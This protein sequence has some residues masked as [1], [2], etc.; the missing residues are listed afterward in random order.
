MKT[1][2]VKK[3]KDEKKYGRRD[4]I[5]L[6]GLGAVAVTAAAITEKVFAEEPEASPT[7]WA[8]VIDLRKCYGCHSCSAACKSGNNVQIGNFRSWVVQVEKGQYPL[9][10]RDFLPRLCNQCEN[11][12]CVRVCPTTATYKRPDGIVEIDKSICIGCR[13][14]VNACPFGMRSFGWRRG[15]DKGKEDYPARRYGVTD[16]CD[17]CFHRL[18]NGMVPSCVNTC[19]AKARIIGNIKDKNSEVYKLID[20]NPT[21][22][23]LPD[24]GT[25]PHVYYIGLDWDTAE[26]AIEVGTRQT[27]TEI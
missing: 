9:A 4:I 3:K 5:K 23:L 24:L 19:P 18:E 2:D 6:A 12:A 13:Y 8:M 27:P 20:E 26:K 21:Q 25:D 1:P 15:Y 17:F 16:K 11:P 7:R 14:C 22:R 10:E